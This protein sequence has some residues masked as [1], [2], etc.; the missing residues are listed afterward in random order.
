ML[1]PPGSNVLHQIVQIP[2]HQRS[3]NLPPLARV[4]Y[5][6][7]LWERWLFAGKSK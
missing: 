3:F 5:S 1:P 4:E 6:L 7:F 2:Y